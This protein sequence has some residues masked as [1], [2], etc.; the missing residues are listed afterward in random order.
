MEKLGNKCCSI[1][2]RR[3]YEAGHPR[4]LPEAERKRRRKAAYQ[5]DR[6]KRLAY[7][8]RHYELNRDKI[9]AYHQKWRE[10][11]RER[12]RET[13]RKS[14]AKDPEKTK[15][16]SLLSE[17]K[18]RALRTGGASTRVSAAELRQRVALFG[19]RCFYCYG[20]FEHVD[21]A[22]PLIR[23]GAHTISNLVPACAPCNLSKG[24]KTM[25]E[26]LI[27]KSKQRIQNVDAANIPQYP[28]P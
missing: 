2:C 19:N 20:P 1:E 27:W 22:T 24:S 3:V 28:P 9:L 18:R 4:M 26:F 7:H 6:D 14:K 10:E 21:H 17:A 12:A 13:V 25:L 11:D 8:G 23:G 15:L 5:R 16:S